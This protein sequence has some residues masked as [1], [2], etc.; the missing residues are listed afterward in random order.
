MKKKFNIPISK[1]ALTN[2]DV[3]QANIPL[4]NGWLVQGPFVNK[5]EEKW[6]AFT[7]SKY[8][9]ALNSCTSGLLLG[10][11]ALDLKPGDEVIVPAFTWISTANVVE[12][13]GGKV[14]F[15]DIDL[16]TFNL[17]ISKIEEKISPKTKVIMAV[18]L[19]GL[20][21]DMKELNEIAKIKNIKIIEDAACGFGGKYFDR[22]LGT[23][24]DFGCF[25]FH[26]RKSI[27]TGEGGMLTTNSKMLAEKAKTLRNHGALITDH[28]RHISSKPYFLS[29]HVE[30]GYNFRMTD[31]Q[32][33]LALSQLKRGKKIINDRR[34]IA[35]KYD[36]AFS[37]LNMFIHP[38]KIKGYYHSYQSYACI[39]NTQE[40]SLKNLN[41][42]NKNRNNLMENLFEVGIST[43]PATHA[44][45]LLKYYKKKYSLKPEDFPNALIANDCSISLPLFNG[46]KSDEQN[47]VI[48]N[49]IKFIKNLI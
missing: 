27:T 3:E 19:F 15:C 24:G 16:K 18:H 8:S 1:V 14:V 32:A 17:D 47:F 23:F 43:R 39:L 26:P 21:V 22:H 6:S 29:D 13:A 34:K 2:E 10:L 48:E 41:I 38:P 25:S 36:D 35:K 11:L 40:L 7:G 9:I 12:Q 28:Q 30:A 31:F 20:S 42:I 49:T 45:H 46:L 33:S 5:F 44:V 4:K 37:N